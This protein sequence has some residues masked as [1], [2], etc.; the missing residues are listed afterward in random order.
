MDE[1]E[2]LLENHRFCNDSGV[3]DGGIVGKPLVNVL[4]SGTMRSYRGLTANGPR[5]DRERKTEH[6][7][8]Y[9]SMGA[10]NHWF[11]KVVWSLGE[12]R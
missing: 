7:Y 9:P 11:Y 3:S 12:W 4:G 8:V 6:F 1:R 5:S 2:E 10:N